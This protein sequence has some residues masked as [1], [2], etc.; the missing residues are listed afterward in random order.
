MEKHNKGKTKDFYYLFRIEFYRLDHGDE[1][2]NSNF[3][4]SLTLVI[5]RETQDKRI[6]FYYKNECNRW[7]L[8][9]F[10]HENSL[11]KRVPN[12]SQCFEFL[13]KSEYSAL[14]KLFSQKS[15]T[16][17]PSS[18]DHLA[19]LTFAKF[20]PSEDITRIKSSLYCLKALSGKV[21]VDWNSH[22]VTEATM[23]FEEWM[24]H[25]NLDGTLKSLNALKDS[26]MRKTVPQSLKLTALKYLLGY[27]KPFMNDCDKKNYD[28]IKRNQYE[29]IDATA[30]G[31]EEQFTLISTDNGRLPFMLCGIKDSK[32]RVKEMH[33]NIMRKLAK[34]TSLYWQ[35]FSYLLMPFLTH[36][37][38]CIDESSVFWLLYK[39]IKS[40]KLFL[41]Y[42]MY[43]REYGKP[44]IRLMKCLL[45]LSFVHFDI[46]FFSN[47]IFSPMFSNFTN[48]FQIEENQRF[49]EIVFSQRIS[50][51]FELFMCLGFLINQLSNL[52][53]ACVR[54][55]SDLALHGAF[56]RS[57]FS[58]F[59][60]LLSVTLTIIDHLKRISDLPE[61]LTEFLIQD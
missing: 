26:I 22:A 55:H 27:Y 7:N 58:S 61:S 11:I 13:F 14:Y 53:I 39:L 48:Y 4:Y 42:K 54:E 1:E 28:T 32:E 45:P 31:I 2:K 43:R 35:E 36:K 17:Q 23:T 59:N 30:E 9:C 44:F 18:S 47:H 34:K 40:K 52:N 38:I 3:P 12:T 33:L 29:A 57:S 6:K 56:A 15:N 8:F 50:Q 46:N 25:F 41:S 5:R 19:Y 60:K 20:N 10:F 49:L 21:I 24:A 51:K 37:N 16:F